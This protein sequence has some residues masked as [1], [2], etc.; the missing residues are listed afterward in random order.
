MGTAKVILAINA[1]SSS[2]KTTLFRY[3]EEHLVALASAQVSGFTE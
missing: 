1:G 2:L 3:D